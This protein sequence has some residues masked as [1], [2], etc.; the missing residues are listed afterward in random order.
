MAAT[1][2]NSPT[3]KVFK[4]GQVVI[5]VAL[6]KKYGIEAGKKIEFVETSEGILLKATHKDQAVGSLTDKLYGIFGQ[7][8]QDK[9]SLRKSDIIRA[10]EKGL[11]EKW[12]DDPIS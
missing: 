4:K 12:K 5:P 6:R 8:A 10:T 9:P 3:M 7:F 2:E 11:M 1:G